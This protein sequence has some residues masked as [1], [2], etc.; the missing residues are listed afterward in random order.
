MLHLNLFGCQVWKV[1]RFVVFYLCLEHYFLFLNWCTRKKAFPML[2]CQATSKIWSE[3][4]DIW[5]RAFIHFKYWLLHKNFTI[6]HRNL[7]KPFNE[8]RLFG[9]VHRS[10]QFLLSMWFHCVYS[11]Q[12]NLTTRLIFSSELELCK[13]SIA[14]FFQEKKGGVILKGLL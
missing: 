8:P 6:L 3:M 11:S 5:K 1:L 10:S 2:S 14:F 9:I 13:S 12:L 7:S 4:E